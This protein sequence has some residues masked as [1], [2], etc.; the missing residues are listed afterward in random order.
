[1]ATKTASK[2]AG[3]NKSF[4]DRMGAVSYTHLMEER[5]LSLRISSDCGAFRRAAVSGSGKVRNMALEI[6]RSW[7]KK[8][9]R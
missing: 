5:F 3:T 1:M 9:R 2:T 6:W 4:I 7:P 8:H